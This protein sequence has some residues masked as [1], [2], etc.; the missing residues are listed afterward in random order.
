MNL[1][2]ITEKFLCGFLIY[3]NKKKDE[4]SKYK[5]KN[6]WR[7]VLE[8]KQ[9]VSKNL[10]EVINGFE[11]IVEKLKEVPY[12]IKGEQ[13]KEEALEAVRRKIKGGLFEISEF[14]QGKLGE[15][16]D[17]INNLKLLMMLLAF[18]RVFGDETIGSSC[19]IGCLAWKEG[20]WEEFLIEI[21]RIEVKII[22][23]FQEAIKSL[24]INE[25]N[26]NNQS[27][28]TYNDQNSI[29]N[30]KNESNSI[31]NEINSINNS[32]IESNGNFFI[33]GNCPFTKDLDRFLKKINHF[34]SHLE[35]EK[36]GFLFSEDFYSKIAFFLLEM[37]NREE[38]KTFIKTYFPCNSRNL[39]LS[40][41]PYPYICLNYRKFLKKEA[42]TKLL[43]GKTG[44]LPRFKKVSSNINE[45]ISRLDIGVNGNLS[46]LL[47]LPLLQRDKPG[48]N[49][50]NTVKMNQIQQ[51]QTLASSVL[52]KEDDYISRMMEG[53]ILF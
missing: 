26:D 37:N 30:I 27:N 20:I 2:A 19:I 23:L 39:P 3:L 41:P 17:Y 49:T 18:L 45:T 15:K 34:I 13:L 52:N 32:S 28:L 16:K 51:S 53:V 6:L 44:A 1:F 29:N 31:N 8:C 42:Q 12:F 35:L 33:T 48:K 36:S 4:F 47:V 25:P 9:M 40:N 22:T 14:L 43:I 7:E 11:E 38:T 46:N 5:E 21:E 24:I 10:N 50:L